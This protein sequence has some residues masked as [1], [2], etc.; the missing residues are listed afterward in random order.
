MIVSLRVSGV[1]G[2]APACV[3]ARFVRRGLEL[4]FGAC[5]YCRLD[6]RLVLC[7]GALERRGLRALLSVQARLRYF[8]RLVLSG[9]PTLRRG[10]QLQ[11]RSGSALGRC[12]RLRLGLD[13]F[14]CDA[15]HL[16]LGL[17]L[18]GESLG[19]RLLCRYPFGRREL[20][21]VLRL[22]L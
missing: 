8:P 2:G 14:A 11:L 15:L 10:L 9:S 6:S 3:Q 1:S 4:T 12:T 20:C 18:S 16:T 19:F 22:L 13:F 7:R 17:L 5:A 21:A